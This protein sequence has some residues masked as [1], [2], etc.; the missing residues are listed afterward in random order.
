[1]YSEHFEGEHW[2][3]KR[4]EMKML[5]R[6]QLLQG[7][8]HAPLKLE[9]FLGTDVSKLQYSFISFSVM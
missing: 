3:S 9:F 6:P 8:T 5:P 7:K 1:M 2:K 4:Q